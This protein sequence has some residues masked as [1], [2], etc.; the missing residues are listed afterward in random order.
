M[1]W[2]ERRYILLPTVMCS[3]QRFRVLHGSKEYC[4]SQLKKGFKRSKMRR[5]RDTHGKS[6]SDG[7]N[8]ASSNLDTRHV[9]TEP[10]NQEANAYERRVIRC[11]F[12]VERASHH[13]Y[14]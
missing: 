11:Y 13:G 14:D 2:P 8:A 6:V 1:A 7:A 4:H 3:I 12:L 9:S 5:R 10:G